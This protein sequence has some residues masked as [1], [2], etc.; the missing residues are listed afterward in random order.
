MEDLSHH[1]QALQRVEES[2]VQSDTSFNT[3]WEGDLYPL[4]NDQLMSILKQ[5]DDTVFYA[6]HLKFIE[7]YKAY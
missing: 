4:V 7:T 2:G 5:Q 6:V 1:P 3:K